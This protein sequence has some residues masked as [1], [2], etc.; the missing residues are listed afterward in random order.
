MNFLHIASMSLQEINKAMKGYPLFSISQTNFDSNSQRAD[1]TLEREISFY[2]DSAAA[3]CGE[4]KIDLDVLTF[5]TPEQLRKELNIYNGASAVDFKSLCE[6]A[7]EIAKNELALRCI[8][9]AIAY[10]EWTPPEEHPDWE[11]VDTDDFVSF[12]RSNAVYEVRAAVDGPSKPCENG[13]WD[14]RYRIQLRKVKPSGETPNV[15]QEV[16]KSFDNYK[17]AWAYM[18][19]RVRYISEKYFPLEEPCVPRENERDFTWAGMLLPG[20]RLEGESL[21]HCFRRKEDA[22][23]MPD[24]CI[25]REC[26]ACKLCRYRYDAEKEVIYG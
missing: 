15:I 14:C 26:A 16:E 12:Y 5:S 11:R 4:T 10:Q 2:P 17:A 13:R 19:R 25:G 8:K 18:D 22:K 6:L 24:V 20:Y 9:A 1:L 21:P 7:D 3:P 23:Y